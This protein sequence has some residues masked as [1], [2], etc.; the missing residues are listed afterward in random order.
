M[1]WIKASERLPVKPGE[2][3]TW[4]ARHKALPCI[5]LYKGGDMFL[6]RTGYSMQL[7][8]Y[9]DLMDIEWLDETTS[10]AAEPGKPTTPPD[11]AEILS[12]A[13]LNGHCTDQGNWN[14]KT[15]A[16]ADGFMTGWD[17]ALARIPFQPESEK[18]KEIREQIEKS[19]ELLKESGKIPSLLIKAEKALAAPSPEQNEVSGE[20][21][22]GKYE[23]MLYDYRL[24]QKLRKGV[25]E[26]LMHR[27]GQI[28]ELRSELAALQASPKE[29]I[30]KKP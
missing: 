2:P 23:D 18:T 17:L 19:F 22:K 29:G 8:S 21:W 7:V 20:D 25:Q 16:Y 12:Y 26:D 1:K 28:E 9:L 27:I 13:E 11:Q 30:N 24:E 5:M 10:P 6:L 3:T 15:D 4:N 14:K